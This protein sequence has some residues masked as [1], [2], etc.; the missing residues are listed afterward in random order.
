[1]ALIGNPMDFDRIRQKYESLVYPRGRTQDNYF[2]NVRSNAMG[3][4]GNQGQVNPLTGQPVNMSALTSGG[5][6][7]VSQDAT[8]PGQQVQFRVNPVT[9]AT[10]A[11][12]PEY[13]G[14]FRTDQ[15]DYFPDT[16]GFENIYDAGLGEID[17]TTGR[18]KPDPIIDPGPGVGNVLVASRPGDGGMGG[19]YGYQNRDGVGVNPVTHEVINDIAYR[20]NTV[21]GE[22]EM[23]DGIDETIA[24]ALNTY[25]TNPLSVVGLLNSITGKTYHEKMSDLK[26]LNEDAYNAV[27][28]DVR[29]QYAATQYEEKEAPYNVVE[30]VVGFIQGLLA[31]DDKDDPKGDGPTDPGP[32]VEGAGIDGTGGPDSQYGGDGPASGPDTS[33]SSNDGVG[34]GA[35][36]QGGTGSPGDGQGSSGPTGPGGGIGGPPGGPGSGRGRFR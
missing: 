1:M 31:P 27:A 21:T 3:L 9:G 15:Q 33:G 24:K 28:A 4:L 5:F 36:P 13:M 8:A 14:G 20:I 10:E 32:G 18:P 29:E 6:N 19:Y 22:V 35:G 11:V 25:A 23:L 34:G 12:I 16:G 7:M 30:E 26:D 2:N 17:P